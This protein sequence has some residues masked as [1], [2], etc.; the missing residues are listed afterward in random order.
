MPIL[1]KPLNANLSH[2]TETFGSMVKLHLSRVPTVSFASATSSTAVK[3]VMVVESNPSG[4]THFSLT[5]QL[6]PY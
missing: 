4:M 6:T 5:L 2:D 1:I 3:S